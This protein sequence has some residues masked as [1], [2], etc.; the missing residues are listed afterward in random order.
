MSSIV[1]YVVICMIPRNLSPLHHILYWNIYVISL[2]F[3]LTI[4]GC[5]IICITHFDIVIHGNVPPLHHILHQKCY[6]WSYLR[7]MYFDATH[8]CHSF[9][10]CLCQIIYVEL[11]AL[12]YFI[13]C[14]THNDTTFNV[15]CLHHF[16]CHLY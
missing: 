9:V 16:L 7:H 3:V 15:S 8:K 13:I 1:P 5:L 2:Q 12:F 10:S 4:I 14:I 6:L 11:V